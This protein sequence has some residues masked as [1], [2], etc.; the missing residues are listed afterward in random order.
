MLCGEPTGVNYLYAFCSDLM[1]DVLTS[2]AEHALLVTGLISAQTIRT[3]EM[4]DISCIIFARNKAVPPDMLA[5][6]QQTEI[7][8]LQSSYTVFEICGKLYQAGIRPV[9]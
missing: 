3:A 8:L 2:Y 9:Y 4:A 1:S 5:L 7:T 6:A